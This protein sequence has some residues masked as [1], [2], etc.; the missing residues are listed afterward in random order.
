MSQW[1]ALERILAA[2]LGSTRSG[3]IQLDRRGRIVEANERARSLLRRGDGLSDQ[4]GFLHARVAVD[5]AALQRLLACALPRFGGQ[6][7]GGSM[8]VRRGVDLP[9]LVLHVSPLDDGDTNIRARRVA[10][11]VLIADPGSR[12]R[13]DPE[14]VAA[15][16][17]LTP[18][19]S[20]VA[21]SLAEGRTVRD[22]ARAMGRTENTIRWHMKN[23]FSKHHISRQ[24]E[25]VQQVQALA[26][27]PDLRPR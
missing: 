15:A 25:L 27:L 2:L 17:G 16:L 18:V 24:F 5:N 19:E 26:D 20:R 8:A 6:G 13:I 12:T 3:V 7:V 4:D 21:V 23:M 14:L 1:D 11:L 10:A 9:R 22:I